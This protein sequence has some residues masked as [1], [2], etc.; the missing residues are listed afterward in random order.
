MVMCAGLR[1]CVGGGVLCE[2]AA[3][4]PSLH[5][6]RACW[7]VVA[8]ALALHVAP[9]HSSLRFEATTWLGQQLSVWL[10]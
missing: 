7:W 10:L 9:A 3:M 8:V 4:L 6:P 1:V 2:F 5:L